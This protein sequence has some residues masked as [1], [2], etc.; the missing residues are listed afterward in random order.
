[1][2]Y[3]ISILSKNVKTPDI[4][5]SALGLMVYTTLLSTKRNFWMV[6]E[7]MRYCIFD[8]TQVEMSLCTQKYLSNIHSHVREFS[9]IIIITEVRLIE[10]I[11]NIC[12]FT[13]IVV[14]YTRHLL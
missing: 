14:K 10:V 6:V 7:P 11:F 5:Y 2:I 1:M 12:V 3:C 8:Y 4:L 9:I 13:V